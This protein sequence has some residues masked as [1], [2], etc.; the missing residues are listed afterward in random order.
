VRVVSIKLT[1]T[2][3]DTAA[4]PAKTCQSELPVAKSA[5]AGSPMATARSDINR[6]MM[7]RT[8]PNETKTSPI[9]AVQEGMI[10]GENNQQVYTISVL[11]CKNP[12]Q[13]DEPAS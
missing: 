3:N 1:P 13:K 10:I 4:E 6:P 8:G 9:R 7:K 2:N 11:G 5:I 12:F